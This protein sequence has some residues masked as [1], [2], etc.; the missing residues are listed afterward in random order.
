M[1]AI[2][3]NSNESTVVLTE[4]E[5]QLLSS[6][7]TEVFG[8]SYNIEEDQWQS[9]PMPMSRAEAKAFLAEF[10]DLAVATRSA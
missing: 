1:K 7:G 10:R 8:G 4:R 5:I 3:I 9:V 6:L 2:T